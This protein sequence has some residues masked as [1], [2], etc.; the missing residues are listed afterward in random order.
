MQNRKVATRY[1]ESRKLERLHVKANI[2]AGNHP[3]TYMMSKPVIVRGG[4]YKCEC[5]KLRDQKRKTVMRERRGLLYQNRKVI[6]NQKSIIDMHKKKKKESKHNTKDSH[7]ITRGE[8]EKKTCKNKS[9]TI[10][11]NCNKNIH[12]NNYLK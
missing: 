12:I 5:L 3:H 8:K 2:R 4:E 11:K 1:R 6:T 9:K 7:Q 10:N